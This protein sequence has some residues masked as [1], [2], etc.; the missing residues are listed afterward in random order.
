[1]SPADATGPVNRAQG[2]VRP[3]TARRRPASEHRG[4]AGLSLAIA[5][6]G[7]PATVAVILFGS[8]TAASTGATVIGSI[9]IA[10]FTAAHSFLRTDRT[11]DEQTEV[12]EDRCR[13]Y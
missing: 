2:A 12:T 9:T 5:A 8:G 3:A 1:M 10:A 7:T 11:L 13:P 6:T 4:L